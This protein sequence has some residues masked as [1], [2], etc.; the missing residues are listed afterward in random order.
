MKSFLGKSRFVLGA[1]AASLVLFFATSAQ[2]AEE[3]FDATIEIIA[4]LAIDEVE[5]LDF[6]TVG[7]PTAG[8]ETVTLNGEQNATADVSGDG[9]AVDGTSSPGAYLITGNDGVDVTV[10]GGIT[11]DFQANGVTLTALEIEN[12]GFSPSP[13][14]VVNLDGDGLAT[15]YVGGTVE[16]ESTADEG[17]TDAVITLTVSYTN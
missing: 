12:S 4:N 8:S 1:L 3:D 2:A 6:G 14:Q 5:L 15:I 16:V 17:P 7:K 9:F 13:S 11:T 10:E